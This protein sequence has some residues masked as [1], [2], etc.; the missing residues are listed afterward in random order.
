MVVMF[1]NCWQ[2]SGFSSFLTEF[3][4]ESGYTP[5]DIGAA[6]FASGISGI[7]S[8]PVGGVISDKLIKNGM[9]SMKARCNTMGVAGF[10]MA[11][12]FTA[13]FPYLAKGSV[14]KAVL[15]A[16]FAGWGIP[17]TNSAIGVLPMDLTR[18]ES[19]A[20]RLFGFIML[21]GIGAG[22][23]ISPIVAQIC[24]EKFG[25]NVGIYVLAVGAGVGTVASLAI[26]YCVKC[27]K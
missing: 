12:V 22:G 14:K 20:G 3:M 7:F 16:F 13:I 15:G 19:A 17:L 11:S 4:N 2:S 10:L 9:D 23:M 27:T 6:V 21:V 18:D 25:N 8:T 24:A 5:E 26:P 1:A